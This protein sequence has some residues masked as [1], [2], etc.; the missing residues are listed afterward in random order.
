MPFT[1][2]LYILLASRKANL[3]TAG[4]A[5]YA[6]AMES[7][8][9]LMAVTPIDGRYASRVAE[10]QPF[11]SE[12]GLIKHRV[13]VEA[14]WLQMLGSGILPGTPP[15]SQK[16]NA[17][18]G[19]LMDAFD[20]HDAAEIKTI[21]QTLNH[22]VKAV[23]VWLTSKLPGDLFADYKS[24]VH[25]GCTSE[26]INNLAYALMLRG[27]LQEVMLPQLTQLTSQLTDM[28]HTYAD[29]P[30]LAR[31]HGQ[32][33]SPVTLGKEL[34]V[35]V[36]R[37]RIASS[38]LANV[39]I[40]GKF[41]GATGGY[42]AASIAYPEVDWPAVAKTFVEDTLGLTFNPV[43]TQIESHDWIARVCNEL[44]LSNTILTDLSTDIWQYIS[45]EYFTQTV[46]KQEVG[47]STMPHKVNPINFENAEGNYG[48][49]N[50][51]LTH[52]AA[53]LPRSR[54]QRDL[55]DSTALRSLG[56]AFA[57]TLIAHKSL[58]KGLAGITANPDKM[59]ADLDA[60]WPVL[61]EAIQSIMRRYGHTDAYDVIKAASRGK[62]LT[63]EQY[64][65]LVAGLDIPKEAKDRLL[66]LT[67]ADYTG[68]SKTL[69]QNLYVE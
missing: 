49:A 28:A 41:N 68:N 27:T 8:H 25:F 54:L 59:L 1:H 11:L 22:D 19:D 67:P 64:Q 37:L 62:H 42:S 61:T 7:T 46:A 30:M 39:N 32:P 23:E 5:C 51:L 14:H 43:T 44:S 24:L 4:K 18:L 2:L 33:A 16:A 36:E 10:L 60:N 38:A 50:A 35:F 57:H 47:S 31:T 56:E 48:V 13:L 53:K 29:V 15:L 20:A 3:V 52:L 21:E 58:Q 34:R 26:D 65:K 17:F 12:Y 55:S 9:E 6:T 40:Y 45:N 69:A 63:R 66:A